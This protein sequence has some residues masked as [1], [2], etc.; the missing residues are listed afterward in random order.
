MNRNCS[1]CNKKID[2]KFIKN[3]ELFVIPVTIKIKVKEKTKKNTLPLNKITASYQQT[4]NENVKK[5]KTEH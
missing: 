5:I 3:I 4:K 1:A 2:K